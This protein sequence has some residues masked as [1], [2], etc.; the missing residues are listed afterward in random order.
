[1]QK[2][3]ITGTSIGKNYQFQFTFDIPNFDI[4]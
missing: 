3:V 4:T 1:M 2:T